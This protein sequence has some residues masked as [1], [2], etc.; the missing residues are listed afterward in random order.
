MKRI[1]LIASRLIGDVSYIE[2]LKDKYLVDEFTYP[3]SA[4]LRLNRENCYDLVV[5]EIGPTSYFSSK[6]VLVDTKTG[7]MLYEEKLK[8]FSL[9]VILW[10]R[11]EGFGREEVIYKNDP[12]IFF[13]LKN[14]ESDHLLQA[15]NLLLDNS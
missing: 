3:S 10:F 13:L 9:P 6:E 7:L 15:V 8:E 14:R 5:L 2:K 1:L 12:K 11:K 4:L